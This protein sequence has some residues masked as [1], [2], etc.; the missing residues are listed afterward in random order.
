MERRKYTRFQTQDKCFAALKEKI[1]KVG[2]INDIS[3]EGLSFKYLGNVMLNQELSYVDIFLV[4]NGFHIFNIPCRIVYNISEKLKEDSRFQMS[5]CGLQFG[6][7]TKSQ[8]EQL[9]F[10]IENYTIGV[11]ES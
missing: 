9:D 11:F 8:L 5:Q 7:R 6:E 4:E 2:K 3:I 10:F 1:T